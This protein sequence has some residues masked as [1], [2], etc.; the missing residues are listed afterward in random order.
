MQAVEEA[1][2]VVV[3][4]SDFSYCKLLRTSVAHSVII[5]TQQPNSTVES[6]L[7]TYPNTMG[8]R[9]TSLGQLNAWI[10]ETNF[11]QR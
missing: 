5:S 2:M 7:H 1:E 4:Y 3:I 10:S 6:H 11:L 8:L 9:R